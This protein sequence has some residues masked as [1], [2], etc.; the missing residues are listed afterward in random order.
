MGTPSLR[1]KDQNKLK[2]YNSTHK[3]NLKYCSPSERC[4]AN[5]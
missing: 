1:V 2:K 4:K 5:D 3:K